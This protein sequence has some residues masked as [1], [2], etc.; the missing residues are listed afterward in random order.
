MIKMCGFL[1][2]WSNTWRSNWFAAYCKIQAT[3]PLPICNHKKMCSDL[4]VKL[5]NLLCL[6]GPTGKHFSA[7]KLFDVHFLWKSF[8]VFCLSYSSLNC[9]KK[10]KLSLIWFYDSICNTISFRHFFYYCINCNLGIGLSSW[11]SISFCLLTI[12]PLFWQ[13]NCRESKLD[14]LEG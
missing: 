2:N 5:V 7:F 11:W 1:F 9:E 14:F 3:W 13:L 12:Y 4:R 10:L 6:Q 8:L